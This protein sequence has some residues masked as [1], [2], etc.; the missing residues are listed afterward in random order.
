MT[1]STQGA[2]REQLKSTQSARDQS[3]FV[4]PSE[5]KILCLV[6][7]RLIFMQYKSL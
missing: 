6:N 1:Q 2:L 7:F 4:I 3:D 5:P